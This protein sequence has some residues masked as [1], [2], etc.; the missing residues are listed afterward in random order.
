MKTTTLALCLAG[1]ALAAPALAQSYRVIPLG[2]L[3]G[4]SAA[5]A[6]D[7]VGRVVGVSADE[8]KHNDHSDC[9]DAW[10][11]GGV[12]TGAGAVLLGTSGGFLA[13][14][15]RELNAIGRESGALRRRAAARRAPAFG[16][17]LDL[18]ERKGVRLSWRY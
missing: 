2:S 3:G 13:Q 5:W 17:G 10:I 4:Q 16:F 8:P 12:L 14:R 9:T 1:A 7:G 18:G 11:A 6:F 15:N